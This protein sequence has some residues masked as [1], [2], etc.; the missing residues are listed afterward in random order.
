MTS[1]GLAFS[2][3]AAL[4]VAV[5]ARAETPL[6][7]AEFEAFATGK[8]LDFLRDGVLFGTEAYLPDRRV[9]LATEG[10]GD[11][12][13]GR[14]Y[15]KGG[16]ICFA[17]DALPGEHCWTIWAEGDGLVTLPSYAGP[18]DT[19]R[20]IREAAAPLACAAPYVGS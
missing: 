18:T 2:L 14:W 11:C 5:P 3:V 7:A 8:T 13:P 17:Y 19:P 9:L 4:A 16:L 6:T 10:E 15:D 1:T 20:T 12:L